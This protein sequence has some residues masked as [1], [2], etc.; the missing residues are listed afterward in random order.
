M[1]SLTDS[2]SKVLESFHDDLEVGA[3]FIE[4]FILIEISPRFGRR[5]QLLSEK[6]KASCRLL[7]QTHLQLIIHKL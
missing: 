6:I 4:D 7:V 3:H 5:Y 1:K 2:G